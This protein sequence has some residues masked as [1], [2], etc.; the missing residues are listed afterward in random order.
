MIHRANWWYIAVL[1]ASWWPG[2]SFGQGG[3]YAAIALTRAP[4]VTGCQ[5]VKTPEALAAIRKRLGDTSTGAPS[6]DWTQL[7]IAV[8]TSSDSSFVPGRVLYAGTDARINKNT[9]AAGPKSGA[10]LMVIRASATNCELTSAMVF[11]VAPVRPPGPIV[12]PGAV[13]TTNGSVAI[14][15]GTE[16]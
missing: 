10:Y 9:A 3:A 7:S 2:L 13:V 4:Q 6:I 14:K 1:L 16:K 12:V 5:L 8:I 15:S 11:E